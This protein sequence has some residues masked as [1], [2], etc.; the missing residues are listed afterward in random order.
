MGKKRR[1]TVEI[2]LLDTY[3]KARRNLD[4]RSQATF[5]D[6]LLA[7][8]FGK[9]YF[10]GTRNQGYGGYIYDGRWKS[11]VKRFQENYHLVSGSKILDVGCAKGFM[12]FDFLKEIPGIEVAGIDISE[13]AIAHAM[14]EVKLHV[15]VGNATALPFSDK[16]FDLVISINTVHNLKLPDLKKALSEIERI[17]HRHKFIVVDAYHTEEEKERLL[18]WNLTAET[19]MSTK[20]WID[21]FKEVGYTGDYY[22]FIP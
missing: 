18:K 14:K 16:S 7:K 22:W 21:L 8:K 3:P 19:Y 1:G 5:Q 12:L 20:A 9:E 4:N 11:V 6:R 13:Y 17:S 10:D 2:N 15:E